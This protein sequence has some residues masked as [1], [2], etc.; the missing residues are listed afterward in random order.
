MI[1]IFIAGTIDVKPVL[2]VKT[3]KDDMPCASFPEG[4]YLKM[5]PKQEDV[6]R[7]WC[8]TK[9]VLNSLNALAII[10]SINYSLQEQRLKM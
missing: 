8:F 7:G 5:S 6:T 4:K 2:T 1:C 9:H 3:E 10:S